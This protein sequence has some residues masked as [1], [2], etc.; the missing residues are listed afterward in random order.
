MALGVPERRSVPG[1]SGVPAPFAVWWLIFRKR[2]ARHGNL[3][4][5]GEAL[6]ADSCR[7]G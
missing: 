6:H 5:P 2:R 1:R 3:N 7:G 4:S